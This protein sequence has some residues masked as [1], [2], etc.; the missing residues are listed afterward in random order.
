LQG[1]YVGNRQD[2]DE[3]ESAS[4]VLVAVPSADRDQPIPFRR[5]AIQLAALGKVKCE[6]VLKKLEDLP[7]IY[8]DMHQGRM[9]SVDH[10]G[11]AQNM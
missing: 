5:L 7:Q 4:E 8:E 3:G 9:V 2:A 6:F 1:S 10:A 11:S